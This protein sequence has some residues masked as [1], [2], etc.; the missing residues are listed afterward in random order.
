MT[1]IATEPLSVYLTIAVRRGVHLKVYF[2][3]E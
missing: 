3:M 2:E 1:V